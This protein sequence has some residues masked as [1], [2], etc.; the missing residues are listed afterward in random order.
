MEKLKDLIKSVQANEIVLPDFQRKFTWDVE[1]QRGFI[2]SVL[3]K[4]PVGGIL[5]LEA[6][7][8]AYKPK[9][10]GL[11][12]DCALETT[13]PDTTHFLIDGQQR[14]TCLTNVFSDIIHN[15]ARTTG[16]LSSRQLLAVRFF[17]TLP[18]WE[19]NLDKHTD[20][21][22]VKSLDF[23]VE[24]KGE[25]IPKFLTENIIDSIVFETF[26]QSDNPK[27]PYA[28]TEC[29]KD[30]LD[31]FCKKE[32]EWLVPLFLMIPTSDADESSRYDRFDAILKKIG[33][34]IL[35]RIRSEYC[36]IND[37]DEKFNFVKEILINTTEQNSYVDAPDGEKSQKF[38]ELLERKANRWKDYFKSYLESCINDLDIFEKR[39]KANQRERAIDIYENMN[40][41]G[42][43]LS[44]FDLIAAKAAKECAESFHDRVHDFLVNNR[45]YNINAVPSM[46]NSY[47]NSNYNASTSTEAVTKEGLTS[48]YINLFLQILVAISKNPNYDENNLS[49]D[50]FKANRALD[51]KSNDINNNTKK[52]CLGLDRAMFFL[53]TRCGIRKLSDL[54]NKLMATL[55]AYIFT[56]DDWFNDKKVHDKLEAWY[57]TALF[58]GEYDKDQYSRFES[59]IKAFINSLKTNDFSWLN[60]M[61]DRILNEANF[62]D[63]ELLL[64]QKVKQDRKPKANV[65]NSVCQYFLAKGYDDLVKTRINDQVTGQEIKKVNVFSSFKLEKHHIVPIGSIAKISELT[66]KLRDDDTNIVNSP[67]NFVYISDMANK[68]ILEKSLSEYESSIE[69]TS[70]SKLMIV[71]YPTVADL[72]NQQK[73]LN[74]L[75]E[76]FNHLQ[77]DIKNKVSDLLC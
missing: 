44:T 70:K 28:P 24:S 71:N 76:R 23:T 36:K 74:W 10:L 15:S 33:Q 55:I 19:R 75:D 57:W 8:S 29:L 12:S 42:V 73:I 51:L 20:L 63:K 65:S 27:K 22:G 60:P 52:A 68:A 69:N 26:T 59:N 39:L 50:S 46:L 40:M 9:V 18:R 16:N 43:S 45:E 37:K 17:L 13:I 3:T 66:G 41:G 5:L 62:T 34:D 48:T 58:S 25:G 67:L 6:D 56:K 32:N 21:F 35:L 47:I 31:D 38:E 11:K 53:Q 14:I 49:T 1:K 2:A 54:N 77:G 30:A 72:S 7:S 61:R 64:M 4:L